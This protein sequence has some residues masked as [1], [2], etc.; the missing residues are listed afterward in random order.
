MGKLNPSGPARSGGASSTRYQDDPPSAAASIHSL[1]TYTD[2]D[3]EVE[4]EEE[5][6]DLPPAYTDA[7][8]T[9]THATPATANMPTPSNTITAPESPYAVL[10]SR[11]ITSSRTGTSYRVSLAPE[12]SKNPADLYWVM[13]SHIKL[14]PRPHIHVRGT[15]TEKQRNNNNNGN[16]NKGSNSETVVDFDFTIDGAGTVLPGSDTSWDA[17]KYA[18]FRFATVV[19]DG[20]GINAYRGGRFKSTG[21]KKVASVGG[22]DVEGNGAAG[23][24]EG[25]A[26]L[27]TQDLMQWCERFCQDKAG[28]KSFVLHRTI[29]D[30]NHPMVT[31][32]LTALIRATKYRGD[33]TI[34]PFTHDANLTIYSPSLLNRLRTNPFVWWTCV[35]LQL[36]ILT[37]PLLILLERRYE[38]VN[39]DWYAARVGT[40]ACGM[41]EEEWV[42]FFAPAVRAAAL[43]RRQCANQEVITP[44]EARQ[45]AEAEARQGIFAMAES[46][47]ERERRERINRGEGSWADSIVG[48]VRG[49]SEVRREWDQVAGW[50]GHR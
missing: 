13:S 33:I 21:A 8:P 24:A 39:V 4:E 44:L 18:P 38:V 6:A 50:G 36:W 23:G 46:E 28:V 42:A 41:S 32:R 35:I 40:Y 3:S 48:V 17:A 30:W 27:P 22:G 15:H 5:E 45:M 25:E 14:A 34:K 12:L 9:L 43:G 20:D 11:T 19:A 7:T 1:Q 16:N 29:R 10:G 26:L 47:A 37:W 49:V 31:Q 2:I